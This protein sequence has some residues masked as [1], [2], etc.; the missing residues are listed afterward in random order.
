MTRA[1]AALTLCLLTACATEKPAAAPPPAPAPAGNDAARAEV[2]RLADDYV[3]AFTAAFP[4]AAE[5][6]GLTGAAPDGLS[7]N[8]LA[9]TGRWHAREDAWA[10]QLAAIDGA[11]LW[12]TPEWALH[13][14]LKEAVDASRQ[15]RIC[16][17]EL[18]PVSQM[19]G[20]QVGVSPLAS[21]Q[22]V[23]TPEL[24]AAALRRFAK[25][26][27]YLDTEIANAREGLKQGY[28]SPR[29]VAERT[30]KQIEGYAVAAKDSPLY[31]PA[32]R[33]N[34]P[35]F[36]AEWSA[37]LDQKIRPAVTRYRDFLRDE[38]LSAARTE[39]SVYKNRDGAACYRALFRLGTTLDRPP[40]ETFRLG[41]ARVKQTVAEA[42]A[43]AKDA[44][45]VT[46]LPD[47]MARIRAEPS[48][49]FS[50][51]DDVLAWARTSVARARD[52]VPR[53]FS[54]APAA[55]VLVQPYPAT[56]EASVSDS[57]QPA[58]DDGS[59]AGTYWIKL[60]DHEAQ[61]RS[62]A[63]VTAFHETYPGHHLQLSFAFQYGPKH[64][65]LR[66]TGNSG[67]IEGWGRYAEALADE[68]GLVGPLARIQRRLWPARGMMVDPGIHALGWTREQAIQFVSESGR[69]TPKE[70]ESAM[71]RIAIM[72]AQLTAYDTGALEIFALRDQAR[73]ALGDRFDL[74]A[75][76]DVILSSG[77][78]TLP[79]LR[80]LVEKW[81]QDQKAAAR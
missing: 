24:R 15:V 26:P 79:M 71:E 16:R 1:A 47:I 75:F 18:W 9:A 43:M 50:S 78:V 68:M 28:S 49:H 27:A 39:P 66:L 5:I 57:Y 11:A 77:P 12:G 41:Q 45:G 62:N 65:L 37:L 7:D 81:I 3:A 42:Q 46:A 44:L 61:L 31:D 34:D 70:A 38:Y 17:G 56:L 48:N 30:L 54:H 53:F 8:S 10:A 63:E 51:R 25:L 74:R 36:A 58:A 52:A 35:A 76:H 21:G 2:H 29:R 14:L 64:P 73:A 13:G 32:R 22:R 60:A 59:R 55:D 72:P 67:Y 23:D 33:A 4:D 80:Q 69:F 20:W 40:E 6:N 19:N